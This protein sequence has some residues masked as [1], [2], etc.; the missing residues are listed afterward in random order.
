MN[1]Q[2]TFAQP[3]YGAT[4]NR[5]MRPPYVDPN[6]NI[7]YDTDNAEYEGFLTKQSLWLKEWR[8]RYVILKGAKLFFAKNEYRYVVGKVY[9]SP[10]LIFGLWPPARLPRVD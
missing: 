10:V 3:A 1:P 9:S 2:S 5:L 8:R 4:R 7:I 6:T